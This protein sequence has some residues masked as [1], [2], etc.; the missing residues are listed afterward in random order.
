MKNIVILFLIA[1]IIYSIIYNM[2]SWFRRVFESG[3]SDDKEL[4]KHE[5]E[6]KTWDDDS[7]QMDKDIEAAYKLL[8][9]KKISETKTKIAHILF[10]TEEVFAPNPEISKIYENEREREN[11][12]KINKEIHDTIIKS[13]TIF[14]QYLDDNEYNLKHIINYLKELSPEI[15]RI[16]EHD[17]DTLR[18]Y[19]I[20]TRK[21]MMMPK[22][23]HDIILRRV[24]K[25][26]FNLLI[27]QAY[28]IIAKIK[29]YYIEI[30]RN[31][32]KCLKTTNTELVTSNKILKEENE[33]LKGKIEDLNRQIIEKT[34]K[35]TELEELHRKV[36]EQ[37]KVCNDARDE[38]KQQI[39]AFETE[40]TTFISRIEELNKR[41]EALPKQHE[42]QVTKLQRTIEEHVRHREVCEDQLRRQQG[43]YKD[44]QEEQIKWT[45]INE[46]LKQKQ[47][48]KERELL[49]CKEHHSKVIQERDIERDRILQQNATDARTHAN[50]LSQRTET[51]RTE[52]ET[53]KASHGQEITKKEEEFY[54]F[55]KALTDKFTNLNHILIDD[56]HDTKLKTQYKKYKRSSKSRR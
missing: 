36:T 17:Y 4:F 5:Y 28:S 40:R 9:E 42:E 15:I 52:I 50:E 19:I 35:I 39:N 3:A 56:T 2:T 23:D 34:A 54:N 8:E 43:E 11:F 41:L 16:K 12:D 49:E 20:L 27:T 31:K 38:C 51:H 13:K 18:N 10:I 24:R 32:I 7:K 25:F 26:V 48:E 33:T 14:V 1:N 6:G 30:L 44:L 21:S 22:A 47:E 53:L 55:L 29:S 45:R 37:L 46:E